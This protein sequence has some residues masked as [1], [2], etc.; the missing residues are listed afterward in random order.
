MS[1]PAATRANVQKKLCLGF[2]KPHFTANN[3]FND[4]G[5]VLKKALPLSTKE[6]KN[7]YK[8]AGAENV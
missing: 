6:D 3:R 1:A 7:D 2:I 8:R 5:R 4:K